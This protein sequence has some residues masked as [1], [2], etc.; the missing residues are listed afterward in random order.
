M[1]VSA[2]TKSAAPARRTRP[3]VLSAPAPFVPVGET[4][5][6]SVVA[7]AA[8]VAAGVLVSFDEVVFTIVFAEPKPEPVLVV[9]STEAVGLEADGG[10]LPR[11]PESDALAEADA[12]LEV[13]FAEA[14]ADAPEVLSPYAGGVP[15]VW[16]TIEPLPQEM[17]WPLET[18]L[19]VGGVVAPSELAIAKRPVQYTFLEKGEVNW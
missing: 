1:N 4:A 8:S 9:G 11:P 10:E 6:E 12:E 16:P 2:A 17:V 14:V 18:S 5:D 3:S 13:P 15:G 19:C 7:D